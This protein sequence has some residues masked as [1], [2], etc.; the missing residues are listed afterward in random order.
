MDKVER[1]SL[2]ILAKTT[3]DSLGENEISDSLEKAADT[4]DISHYKQAETEF[5]SLPKEQKTA[6]SSDADKAATVT[7][8]KI[9]KVR[10]AKLAQ[11]KDAPPVPTGT[12]SEWA[13][14]QKPGNSLTPPNVEIPLQTAKPAS[15]DPIFL[16]DAETMDWGSPADTGKSGANST[17]KQKQEIAELR[18]Q[19]LGPS[20][21]VDW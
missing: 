14:G 2:R 13:L 7:Q 17:E 21:K 1:T 18:K 20:N 5:D 9:K 6:L 16:E 15:G 10:A 8:K 19:M 4:G 3:K 11:F 12:A